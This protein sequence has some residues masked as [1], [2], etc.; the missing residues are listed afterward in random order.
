[1]PRRLFNALRRPKFPRLAPTCI[2]DCLI[3]FTRERNELFVGLFAFTA[4]PLAVVLLRFTTVRLGLFLLLFLLVL[5]R[6]VVALLLL[7]LVAF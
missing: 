5:G 7:V 2:A 6:L 1:M 4:C 3:F